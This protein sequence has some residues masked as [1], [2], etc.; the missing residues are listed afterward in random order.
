MVEMSNNIV[1]SGFKEVDSAV[2]PVVKKIIENHVK[3]FT[4]HFGERFRKVTLH[5][6]EV[7][8]R[9]T[10]QKFDLAIHLKVDN[11]DY[12]AEYTDR[13]LLIAVDKIFKK[14]QA[15]MREK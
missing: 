1:L 5:L 13:D 9:E 2:L 6:K 15:E 11:R 8:K 14:V 4:S 10:S 7:H 12:Y 3:T